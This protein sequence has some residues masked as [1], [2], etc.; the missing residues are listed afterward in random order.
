MYFLQ[1]KD[2]VLRLFIRN[3]FFRVHL[4]EWARKNM[5]KSEEP[6][7]N[8]VSNVGFIKQQ[9]SLNQRVTRKDLSMILGS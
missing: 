7:S 8:T 1:W 5:T 3:T 4:P 2:P 6:D 9:P